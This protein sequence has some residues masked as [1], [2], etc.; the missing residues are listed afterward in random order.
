V[1]TLRVPPWAGFHLDLAL[2]MVAPD[3]V[4]VWAPARGS[5]RGHRWRAGRAG[6]VASALDDP[7]D[8][9]PARA[10]AIE[11]GGLATPEHGRSWDRG[12]NVLPLR[13]GLVVAYADNA[14]ANAQ[15]E[16]AGIEVIPI[17][18]STLAAGRGGP[19]CLSCPLVREA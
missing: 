8:A 12:V 14:A 9:F 5:L 4:A 6:I 7:L 19:R 2:T 1:T 10:S 3:A 18:G 11:I 15:L 17:A 13:P 16:T